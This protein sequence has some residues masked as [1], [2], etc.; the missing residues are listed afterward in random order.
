MFPLPRVS[1]SVALPVAAL[2]A[3]SP[4]SA[5]AAEGAGA[6]DPA[7][8]PGLTW[9]APPFFAWGRTG[10]I[11]AN[12]AEAGAGSS[13]RDGSVALVVTPG[14]ATASGAAVDSDLAFTAQAP[15]RGTA[16]TGTATWV[17][18][19]DATGTVCSQTAALGVPLGAGKTLSFRPTLR[20]NSVSWA[21]EG[22]GDCQDIAVRPLT[23]T[24]PQGAVT[25]RLRVA[26]Q[27]APAADRR[28]GTADWQIAVV[29]GRFQL[30]VLKAQSSVRTR[31]RYALRVGSR[32]VSTGALSVVRTFRP[33]RTIVV[34]DPAFQDI[35]VHGI[36]RVQWIGATVGCKVPAELSMR[37]KL[38]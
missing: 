31:L 18:A 5:S 24:V 10:R 36:Y 6:C 13:Y 1:L 16:M 34:A 8:A 4:V 17:L 29:G 38:T 23:L 9:S 22:A 26:D 33:G 37:L 11:G 35:C 30:H 28:A 21:A 7:L 27:G 15:A 25:R 32:R 19:D 2:C 14:S 3:L 12:I 20:K